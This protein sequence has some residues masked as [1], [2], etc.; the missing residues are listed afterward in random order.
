L[1]LDYKVVQGDSGTMGGNA[2]PEFVAMSDSGEGLIAYCNECEYAATD[3]KAYVVY[4][5]ENEGVEEK[6]LEKVYTPNLKTI[7]D[8]VKNFNMDECK[9]NKVLVYNANNVKIITIIPEDRYL[10]EVKL[11]YYLEI[12]SKDMEKADEDLINDVSNADKEYNGPIGLKEE[13]RLLI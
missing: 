11:C 5:I 12:S 8:L 9:I 3:E 10:N 1:E 6:E 13:T 7:E 4:D 2:S